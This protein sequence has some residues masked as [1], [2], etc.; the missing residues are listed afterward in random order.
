MNNYDIRLNINNP[1]LTI[2]NITKDKSLK[3]YVGR[4][5]F[6]VYC[7]VAD[8]GNIRRAKL[9]LKIGKGWIK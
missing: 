5:Y 6:K 1:I 2:R 4:W 9:V 3:F 8:I 7:V